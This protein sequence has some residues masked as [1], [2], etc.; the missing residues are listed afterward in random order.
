MQPSNT[1]RAQVKMAAALALP[2]VDRF[3]AGSIGNESKL[4]SGVEPIQI[5]TSSG[6]DRLMWQVS[7][8][9]TMEA[10]SLKM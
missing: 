9:Q 7:T 1:P 8:L 4:G 2:R 3:V 6:V 5:M 10:Q